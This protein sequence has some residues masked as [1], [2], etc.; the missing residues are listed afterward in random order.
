VLSV[1]KRTPRILLN[2]D[3]YPECVETTPRVF[4]P[5]TFRFGDGVL[6]SLGCIPARIPTPNGNYI[7]MDMDVVQADVPMIIGLEVLDRECLVADNV[8]NK[9]L[10]TKHGWS[11]PITRKYGHL[12]LEWTQCNIL[13]SK[14]DIQKLHLQFYHPSADKLF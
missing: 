12:Y 9:L 13:Y 6:K 10:S 7:K 5:V 2:T 8:E 14:G 1:P 3:E 11:L 4:G